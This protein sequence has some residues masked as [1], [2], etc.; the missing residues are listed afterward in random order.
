MNFRIIDKF[1]GFDLFKMWSTYVHMYYIFKQVTS[2]FTGLFLHN[3]CLLWIMFCTIYSRNTGEWHSMHF[4]SFTKI[5]E[6]IFFSFH[7]IH[8]KTAAWKF[9][10]LYNQSFWLPVFA[11]HLIQQSGF[12]S[13]RA[14]PGHQPGEEMQQLRVSTDGHPALLFP[15]FWEKVYFR[16][17]DL[18]KIFF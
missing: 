18:K 11:K 15:F 12:D 4:D 2:N 7:P 13:S 6:H 14:L 16:R 17:G 3:I 5:T 1:P 10:S 8:Q 9:L